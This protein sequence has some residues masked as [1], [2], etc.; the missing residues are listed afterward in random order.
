MTRKTI[1]PVWLA[2]LALVGTVAASPSSAQLGAPK[3]T[4]C[5][6]CQTPESAYF[7]PRTEA[8]YVSSIA[9][10]GNEKDGKGWIQKWDKTGKVLSKEW[11]KGL[12]APKGMRAFGDVLWVTDI[13][14][15]VAVDMKHGAILQK[16]PAPGAKFLNDVAIKE[17]GTVFVSDTMAGTIYTL[18]TRGNISVFAQGADLEAPN[19][20]LV[21]GNEL[22]V[23]SWGPGIKEDWSSE[24]PGK[25]YALS[26]KTKKRRDITTTPLG[27][28]DGLEKD[29]KGNYLVSDWT[30]GKVFRV[31]KK[32]KVD[33]LLENLKGPADIGYLAKSALLVV[34]RMNEDL[35][36]GYTLK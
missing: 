18:D 10:A 34:P 27:H 30:I 9:G 35:I 4:N 11:I 36:S 22:I 13:D 29:S 31:S 26:L 17:D 15:I 6:G 1:A 24:K 12:N 28:L 3:W 5:D 32:G 21:D 23:A 7:D 20:L 19:G 33:L 14:E 8:L 2:A 16:I 25:L